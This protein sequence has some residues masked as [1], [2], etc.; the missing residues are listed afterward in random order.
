MIPDGDLVRSRV[1]ADLASALEDALDRRIDGYAIVTPREALLGDA[2]ADDRGVITFEDGVPAL[3]YHV[4]TD[5][6]GPPALADIGTGPHRFELYELDSNILDV[7]HTDDRL[8]VPPGMPAE[9]LAG[10][11]SLAERTRSRS[12]TDHDDDDRSAIE[13]FLDDEATI[14]EIRKNARQEAERRAKEWE[15]ESAI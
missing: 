13:A 6:G 2:D 5:R 11:P 12:S 7:P 1:V 8:R 9:R 10:D 14:E 15:F 4:G 3:V